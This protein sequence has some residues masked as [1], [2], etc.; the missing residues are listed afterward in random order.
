MTVKSPEVDDVA[1]AVAVSA[2]SVLDVA[3]V[4]RDVVVAAAVVVIVRDN[5]KTGRPWLSVVHD[6]SQ[7]SSFDC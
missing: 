3:A 5:T 1:V 7:K 6:D 2:T 4:G